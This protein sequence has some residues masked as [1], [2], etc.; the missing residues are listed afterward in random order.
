MNIGRRL[1]QIPFDKIYEGMRVCWDGGLD[2]V[3]MKL[4]ATV[5]K[6][7]KNV[8]RC[9]TISDAEKLFGTSRCSDPV[10]HEHKMHFGHVLN[11][12]VF[13][14]DCGVI[15]VKA[16]KYCNDYCYIEE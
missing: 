9:I 6:T 4:K 16:H 8:P 11:F 7:K 10:N 14:F 1:D 3:K 15:E 5:I 13:E 2:C 12:V